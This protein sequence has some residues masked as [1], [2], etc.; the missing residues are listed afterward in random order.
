MPQIR[1]M[2]VYVLI[3]MATVI[4]CNSNQCVLCCTDEYIKRKY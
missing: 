1:D 2:Y 4:K 3:N